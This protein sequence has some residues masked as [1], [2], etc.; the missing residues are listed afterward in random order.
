MNNKLY[1]MALTS[2]RDEDLETGEHYAPAQIVVT[3]E[4]NCYAIWLLY[5]GTRYLLEWYEH[6]ADQSS[7]IHQAA[8]AVE[9]YR[10]NPDCEWLI[11]NATARGNFMAI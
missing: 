3:N 10:Q 4:Q 8:L 11:H 6:S 2:T 5:R 9:K 1:S 7:V